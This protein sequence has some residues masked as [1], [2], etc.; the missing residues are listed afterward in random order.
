MALVIV[1]VALQSMAEAGAHLSSGTVSGD[2]N[3]PSIF[4]VIA[5]ENLLSSLKPA[6]Q[7]IVRVSLLLLGQLND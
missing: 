7:H 4:E 3:R 5:Q 2:D 1:D 6:L